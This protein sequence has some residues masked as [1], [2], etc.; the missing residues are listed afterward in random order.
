MIMAIAKIVGDVEPIGLDWLL[1]ED[2]D[3]NRWRY[4][5][6]GR[7]DFDATV[8]IDGE[9]VGTG[10]RAVLVRDA[11]GTA[12]L[13]QDGPGLPQKIVVNHLSQSPPPADADARILEGQ[14]GI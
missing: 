1:V 7:A 5:K 11:D 13:R 4:T 9:V 12:I 2:V 6:R 10:F 3:G 14:N 8:H